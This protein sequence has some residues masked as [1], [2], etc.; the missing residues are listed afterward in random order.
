MDVQTED[1]KKIVNFQRIMIL[2]VAVQLVLWIVSFILPIPFLCY[3]LRVAAGL[4]AAYSAY[5]LST[6]HKNENQWTWIYTVCALFLFLSL[7]PAYMLWKKTEEVLKAA[8]Y[9]VEL[10]ALLKNGIDNTK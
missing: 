10:L 3:I 1:L 7:W 8:G 9:N 6:L 4:F 2:A 5:M